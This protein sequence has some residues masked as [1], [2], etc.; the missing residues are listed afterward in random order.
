MKAFITEV[1]LN[2]EFDTKFG[3][4]YQY[5]IS[6]EDK[7]AIYNS[8]SDNQTY[9]KSGQEIEFIEE[10]QTYKGQDGEQHEYFKVK[11]LNQK[12]QSNFGKALTREQSRYS[13]FAVS[14]AKDLVVAGVIKFDDIIITARMLFDEMVAMD[15]SL[16]S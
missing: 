12:R 14:Y 7:K 1:Q 16:E 15:K 13:G 2:K 6:Y 4:M 3:K 9:F 8:K 10:V 5:F 11:P